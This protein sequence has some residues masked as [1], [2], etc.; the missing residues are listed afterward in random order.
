MNAVKSLK[1]T[2][3][4]MRSFRNMDPPQFGNIAA[5]FLI[6]CPWPQY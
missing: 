6:I 1:F 4:M 3:F 2:D 5:Q